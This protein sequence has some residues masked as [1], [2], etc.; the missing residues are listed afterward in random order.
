[1]NNNLKKIGIAVVLLSATMLLSS[2]LVQN[3]S[4]RAELELLRDEIN[5]LKDENDR[6]DEA[7]TEIRV[8]P[9]G[10]KYG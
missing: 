6:L 9:K 10:K 4:N 2:L 7:I 3:C 8:W 1:M 5:T